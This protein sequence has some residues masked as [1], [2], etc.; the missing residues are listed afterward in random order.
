[1]KALED[2]VFFFKHVAK[3]TAY[4]D[5]DEFIF[6]PDNLDLEEYLRKKESEGVTTLR[7][8]SRHFPHRVCG[9]NKRVTDMVDYYP[10]TKETTFRLW[11]PKIICVTKKFRPWGSIHDG[12]TLE[13]LRTTPPE[14]ELRFNH[15][16]FEYF[17]LIVS[18]DYSF[19]DATKLLV[20]DSLPKRY[21]KAID[22]ICKSK[23]SEN[24]AI[25]CPPGKEFV[26]CIDAN[27]NLPL[28]KPDAQK[29]K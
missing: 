29:L 1:M 18:I 17:N 16:T 20:D 21:G 27:E 12:T 13:G 23:C 26:Y 5:P 6:S 28:N 25:S 2:Y 9:P 24:F 4:T 22:D 11:A 7:I 8:R 15:Y 14:N 10:H 3:F 19:S